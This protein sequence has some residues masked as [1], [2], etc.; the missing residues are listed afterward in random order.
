MRSGLLLPRR[1]DERDSG[2]LRRG[3]L[4]CSGRVRVPR[5]RGGLLHGDGQHVGDGQPVQC[6]RLL[7]RRRNV[8]RGH[9]VPCWLLLPRRL[10]RGDA[11][12][13]G[14]LHD[15]DG[16]DDMHRVHGRLLHRDGQ[17]NGNGDTLRVGQ[18]LPPQLHERR[19][20]PGLHCWLLLRGQC[21]RAL[22]VRRR[23]LFRGVGVDVLGLRRWL[24]HC[25]GQYDGDVKPMQCREDVPGE[26]CVADRRG[27]L[28]VEQVLPAGRRRRDRGQL[29]CGPRGRHWRTVQQRCLRRRVPRGQVL[30]SGPYVHELCCGDDQR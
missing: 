3:L 9:D 6:G 21:Q 20:V 7:R 5:V 15:F 18:V 4:F 27:E 25:D 30:D 11:V 13:V 22:A 2:H 12:S 29:P 24:L 8:A 26:R 14:L 28:C 1:L 10:G 19:L 17:H 23:H 16:R